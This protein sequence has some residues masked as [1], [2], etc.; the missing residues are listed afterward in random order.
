MKKRELSTMNWYKNSTQLYKSSQFWQG[1]GRGILLGLTPLLVWLEYSHG[2]ISD[3]IAQLN[4]SPQIVA[5]E[6]L[7][8]GRDKKA[9]AFIMELVQDNL[10]KTD[11]NLTESQPTPE[12]LTSSNEALEPLGFDK[13]AF[14]I[15]LK[16]NEGNNPRAY[17]V[18]NT[19]EIDIGMG[20]VMRFPDG[21]NPTAQ[22]RST[23]RRLFGD[24]VNFD[25]VLSG[26]AELSAGQLDQLNDYEIDKHL[27]RAKRRLPQFDTY[28]QEAQFAILDAIYRGDMG[29]DTTDFINAGNFSEAVEEYLNHRG[30]QTAVQRGLPGIRRRMEENQEGLKSLVQSEN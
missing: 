17:Q 5:Q 22:S 12:S 25:Q 18:G 24:T 3:L 23:F 2:D 29:K 6:I 20:H 11:S 26:Q 19:K 9:P 14:K 10:K 27:A 30:Y 28:P 8:E 13:D 4:S 1:I 21:K 15:R 7:E 16:R